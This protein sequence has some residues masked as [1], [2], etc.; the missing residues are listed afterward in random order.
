MPSKADEQAL[1]L[2]VEQAGVGTI[3]PRKITWRAF[4]G[5]NK[6][7][8]ELVHEAANDL[9]VQLIKDKSV[10]HCI[11]VTGEMR[12]LAD[13]FHRRVCAEIYQRGQAKFSLI[14]NIPPSYRDS[15]EGVG[16]WNAESW[17]RSGWV[18][19]L[20]AFSIIGKDIIDVFAYDTLD[21]IQFTVFGNRYVLLQERHKDEVN[22]DA[23]G[24]P[25]SKR[26]WLLAC[27]KLNHAFSEKASAIKGEAEALPDALFRRFA[28]S[29][30]GVTSREIISRLIKS[31]GSGRRERIIDDTLHR[32]DP[33]AEAHLTALK[34]IGFVQC[35]G[36]STLKITDDGRQYFATVGN[37]EA[38]AIGGV[39]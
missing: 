18:D 6:A 33:K 9:L 17:R 19:R 32:Y 26:V 10:G 12:A 11:H 27:E 7:E 23:K 2:T 13:P 5:P 16:Q 21:K 35:D 36:A 39:S 8:N 28:V 29:I 24:G 3:D 25:I 38:P 14:Y 15:P 31:G 37:V 20:S 4:S 34:T 30:H 22:E 1:A